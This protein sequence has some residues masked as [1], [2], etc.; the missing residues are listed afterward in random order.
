VLHYLWLARKANPDPYHYAAAL[1]LLLAI[2]A[3][4][5]VWRR[6]ARLSAASPS[7]RPS[8]QRGERA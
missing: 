7:P 1:V 4:D 2:R 5:W 3:G 8:P 6:V